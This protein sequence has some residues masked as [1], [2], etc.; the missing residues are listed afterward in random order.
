MFS[1][2]VFCEFIAKRGVKLNAVARAMGIS[3]TT[4]FR[5]RTGKSEF[6]IGEIR[7]CCECFGVKDM[8][9]IFFA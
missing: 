2:E 8:N 6:T 9:E 1:D 4:L 3:T 5:K 7:K